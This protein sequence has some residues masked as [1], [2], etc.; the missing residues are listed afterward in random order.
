MK[1]IVCFLITI[2]LCTFLNSAETLS[3]SL[4]ERDTNLEKLMRYEILN[5]AFI[6]TFLSMYGSEELS[7]SKKTLSLES[8]LEHAKESLHSKDI[9]KDHFFKNYD[10]FTD[11]EIAELKAIY[12]NKSYQKYVQHALEIY[13]K[14]IAAL[15]EVIREI[16]NEYG[17]EKKAEDSS[18]ESLIQE[19]T[20]DSWQQV[21][22]QSKNP[23]AVVFSAKWCKPCQN[24]KPILKDLSKKYHS[25]FNFASV[26]FD[27]QNELAKKFEIGSLPTILFFNQGKLMFQTKGFMTQ[28]DL[29]A[30]IQE[31]TK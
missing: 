14:N 5:P 21:V 6:D 31:L 7:Q 28:K 10:I 2:S 1:Y 26:D 3:T 25:K 11:Q 18:A 27:A 17:T 4:N 16:I 8:L 24:L 23:I 22:E 13:P 29:E 19:V 20:K 30:K 15:Q 9:L 12:E